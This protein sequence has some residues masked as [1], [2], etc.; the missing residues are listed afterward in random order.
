MKHVSDR[1]QRSRM[2]ERTCILMRMNMPAFQKFTMESRGLGFPPASK[3]CDSKA[4]AILE[5]DA[6][7]A[8]LSNRQSG[9][10]PMSMMELVTD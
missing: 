1:K 3:W 5:N 6:V 10:S 7:S 9:A 8:F 4:H 2:G